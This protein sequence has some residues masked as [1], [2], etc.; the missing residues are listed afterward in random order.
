MI[1]G[2]P[3]GLIR[4]TLGEAFSDHPS[5]TTWCL[6]LWGMARGS[7]Q[8]RVRWSSLIREAGWDLVPL[9]PLSASRP[10]RVGQGSLNWGLSQAKWRG[11]LGGSGG[12]GLH[13]A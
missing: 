8:T 11:R 10:S 4:V 3:S 13:G 5:R 6:L 2:L 9:L 1:Q 12:G 7:R